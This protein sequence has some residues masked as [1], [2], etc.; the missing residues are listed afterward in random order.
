MATDNGGS[1]F[2]SIQAGEDLR[3]KLYHL[4][5]VS[6]AG[7]AIL[8]T[9]GANSVG[10]LT[11]PGNID[12]VVGVQT[13]GETPVKLGGSVTASDPLASDANG[14]AVTA[15]GG[16]SVA[17][18]A[19]ESGSA[20]E[21]ITMI[22]LPKSAGTFPAG[23]QGGIL[24]HN[25]STWIML[26][27]DTA[28]KLF[29]TG[30]P[31]AN[32]SWAY[33]KGQAPFFF[34]MKLA[35]IADGDLVTDFIPGFAGTIKKFCAIVSD[36]ATTSGKGSTLHPEIGSTP[37]TGGSLALTSANMATL[38][39]AVYASAITGANTFSASDAISIVAASTTPFIEG[40]VTLV[41]VVEP[42]VTA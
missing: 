20:D 41:L 34:H 23:V 33:A 21:E 19:K 30:G 6:T 27:P 7:K 35:K 2:L 42:V 13:L 1:P 17:G 12:E 15:V 14:K 18:I 36:P 25:G 3:Q 4:I 24:C 31:S 40:E 22:L 26:A 9:A 11:E 39:V 5:K 28:G 8:A 29:K 32:A 16:D 38:G 37:V 10:V